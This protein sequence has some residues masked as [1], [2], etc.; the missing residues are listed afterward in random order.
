[1]RSV[2]VV[3]DDVDLVRLLLG[4]LGEEGFTCLSA[5]T[6]GEAFAVLAE[7]AV[8]VVLLD[9]HLPD[10][11]GFEILRKLRSDAATADLPVLMLTIRGD[12][13]DKVV[14][15]EMGADDYM[16]KPF[17]ARELA[18]RLRA[19][20]RRSDRIRTNG[21][22]DTVQYI[23]DLAVHAKGHFVMVNGERVDLTNPEL[24]LLSLL[25]RNVGLVSKRELLNKELFG[26]VAYSSDRSLDVL[27]SRLRKKL[28]PRADGG[29]RIRA[30][31][32]EGYTFL[33]NEP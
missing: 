32:G 19:L 27:V 14:G 29:E 13:M 2:L 10:S 28:G 30:V 33:V 8:D 22:G 25:C 21:A 5:A 16:S 1:M 18:A 11:S 12:E 3:D 26:H 6:A 4:Y 20:I 24:T 17:S 9:V 7:S 31:R 23:D 15:L